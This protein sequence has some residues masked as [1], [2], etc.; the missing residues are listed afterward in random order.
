MNL[1][2]RFISI[3]LFSKSRGPLGVLDLCQTPFRVYPTDLDI[4]RHMNNGKYFSLQDLGRVDLM[5]RSGIAAVMKKNGWYPV[6]V[7]ETIQFKKSLNPFEKFILTSQALCW[8]EKHFILEH[9]F[10]KNGE[11]KAYGLIKARF[12]KS[13]GGT[14]T[15]Q[16]F[17]AAVGHEQPSPP[18][19]D[20]VTT[21][22]KSSEQHADL[23]LRNR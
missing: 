13:S 21:W 8:D 14:V 5:I 6:V 22:I 10:M 17:M 19:P 18:F 9:R 1:I 16:E 3:L 11:V 20:Y 15:T 2:F 23:S 7:A 4:L 12:L